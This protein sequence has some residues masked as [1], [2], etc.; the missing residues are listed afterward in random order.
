MRHF[1]NDIPVAPRNL[2]SIGV[3]SDFSDNPDTLKIT[4]D[5]VVLPREAY[6]II[7]LHIAQVGLFEGIPYR[8]EMDGVSIEYYVD[9]T[10]G[11]RVRQHE[12]EV[13][14]KKRNG[15]DNFFERADGT[16]FELL[17]KRGVQFTTYDVPYFV[18]PDNQFETFLQLSVITYIMAEQTYAVALEISADIAELVEVSTPIFGLAS[19]PFVGIVVSYNVGG[20]I[21]ASLILVARLIYFGLMLVALI[22]LATQ[23]YLVIFPPKRFLKGIYFRELLAKSCAYFGYTF[24]SSLLDSEPNW[25]LLPVPLVSGRPSQYEFLPEDVFPVFNKGIPTSSD[26]T[27]T[28]LAFLRGL[29]TMFNARTIVRGGEVRLERRDW[30]QNQTTLQLTP[31]L[32]LQSKRD[33]E[34]T[35]NTEDVWK[36]YYIHYRIDTQD[37]NTQDGLTYDNS[38][39]ELSTEATFPITNPDLVTIK[40]LNDVEIPFALACRKDKLSFV[41][42][43]ARELLAS[44]DIL[45]GLFGNGTNYEAQITSRKDAVRVSQQYFMQTKVLYGELSAVNPNEIIQQQSYFDYVGASALWKKYHYI[46]AI[47]N[48]DFI[49]KENVRIRI[50]QQDFVSL[51]DNNYAELNGVLC[52]IL[53]LEWIDEKSYAKIT[54]KEPNNWADNKVET[55]VIN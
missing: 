50:T 31:A 25:A 22:S 33:D 7:K 27:P 14:I 8:V 11:V 40:G 37:S 17:K 35:Y 18:I 26:S 15:H 44:I 39:T 24:E 34:F 16:T 9:L 21:K 19:P 6:D 48:N 28:L 43:T 32:S 23:L 3:V 55:I 29:E 41:E 36:R 4:V 12:V 1:L 2:D 53:Q 42:E 49:I 30:L 47:Q 45:T 20:I 52:E 46:N 54:Y 51:L 5:S 10:T 13:N 38:D